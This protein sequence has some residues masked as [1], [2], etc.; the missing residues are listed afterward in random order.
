MPN[1]S[2]LTSYP[3]MPDHLS[4]EAAAAPGVSVA[5]TVSPAVPA[6]GATVTA[7]YVVTGN[8]SGPGTPVVVSGS[9]TV[10]GTAIPVTASFTLPGAP[11]A[12]VTYATP[13][14]PGLTFQPT[15]NPAV[16]TAVVP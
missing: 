15:A 3:N 1:P 6:H 10:D 13:T 14:C 4:A 8:T 2:A 5:M 7:T 16:F 11:S 9:V 12:A